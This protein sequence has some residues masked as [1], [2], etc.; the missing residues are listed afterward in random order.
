MIESASFSP[1]EERVSRR[2]RRMILSSYEPELV[3]R[4]GSFLHFQV[5]PRMLVEHMM[6]SSGGVRE[7]ALEETP[8]E[9]DFEG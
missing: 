8:P 9:L 5:S 1:Q 2:E 4:R 7:G 3:C 6:E